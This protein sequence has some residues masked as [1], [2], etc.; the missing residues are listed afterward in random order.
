MELGRKHKDHKGPLLRDRQVC[1]HRFLKPPV[2]NV[3]ALTLIVA[4][5]VIVKNFAD[6]SFEALII[7]VELS[8]LSPSC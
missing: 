7:I 8:S 4:F 1:L 3:K 2:L 6:G 5:S